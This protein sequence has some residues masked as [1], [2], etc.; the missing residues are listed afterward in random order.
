MKITDIKTYF[1]EAV[2]RNWIFLEVETDSGITGI[3]EVTFEMFDKA[4]GG[5]IEDFKRLLIGENPLEIERLWEMLVRRKFWRGDTLITSALSGIE[6]ALWDIKGK[7]FG[8]PIYSL[9]G[10][11]CRNSI[12]TYGNYWF[13]GK[14]RENYPKT[15]DDYVIKAEEAVSKGWKALKW[16][17]FGSAAYNINPKQE[18][19]IVTCVKMVREAVGDKVDLLLDAHGRFNLPTAIRIAQRLEPYHPFFLEE[20]IPPEN[21]DAMLELKKSTK[22]PLAGGERLVTRHQFREVLNKFALD[23][24]QPDVIHCGGIYETK[25]IAAMAETYYIPVIPHNPCGPVA[26]AA[27]IHLAASIPNFVMLEYIDVPER[28]DV[29]IEPLKLINGSFEIPD[30]PGLGVELNKSVFSKYPYKDRE[31]DHY[32]KIRDIV[33]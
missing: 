30:K 1:V 17:P 26:T 19:I 13:L 32:A 27:A 11:P 22:V 33:I 10:G 29:L 14:G 31:W 8:A 7:E 28:S 4:M 20:L 24:I 18:E 23:Y 6:I 3:G 12:P 15:V 9:L 5:A 21:V 25:K 2:R 16:S